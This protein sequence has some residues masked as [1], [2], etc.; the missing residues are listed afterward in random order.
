MKAIF[1]QNRRLSALLW[2]CG[3]AFSVHSCKKST[4]SFSSDEQSLE[5]K[6]ENLLS[7]SLKRYSHCPNG[8]KSTTIYAHFLEQSLDNVC[9]EDIVSN[10]GGDISCSPGPYLVEGSTIDKSGRWNLDATPDYFIW[11]LGLDSIDQNIYMTNQNGFPI[12]SQVIRLESADEAT[13]VLLPKAALDKGSLYYIYSTLS[14]NDKQQ[15]FIQPVMI[16]RSAEE[17]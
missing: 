15:T 3:F 5:I 10:Q 11:H 12:K 16:N 8:E 4:A 14:Q 9:F 1:A 6:K 13:L 17:Y 2:A 7:S